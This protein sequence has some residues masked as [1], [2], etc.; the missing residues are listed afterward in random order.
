MEKWC[1][2]NCDAQDQTLEPGTWCLPFPRNQ[3]LSF[4]GFHFLLLTIVLLVLN[5]KKG[6]FIYLASVSL[7]ILMMNLISKNEV[8]KKTTLSV[9]DY[10]N[11]CNRHVSIKDDLYLY[12]Y[13][14]EV[15]I[16]HIQYMYKCARVCIHTHIWSVNIFFWSKLWWHAMKQFMMYE[17]VPHKF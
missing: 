7:I 8:Q 3:L 17:I 10:S 14:Y 15:F 4:W 6:S 11:N 13:M 1:S 5:C 9:S 16:I 2:L 12:P